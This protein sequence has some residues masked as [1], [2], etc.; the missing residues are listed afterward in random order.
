MPLSPED[1]K[2]LDEAKKKLTAGVEMLGAAIVE[3]S[4]AVAKTATNSLRH[5]LDEVEKAL[6]SKPPEKK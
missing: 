5:W 1:K 6:D 4:T 2:K 3:G